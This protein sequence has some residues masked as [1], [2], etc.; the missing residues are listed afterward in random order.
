MA[1]TEKKQQLSKGETA[2]KPTKEPPP[3]RDTSI[4]GEKPYLPMRE[5]SWKLRR[6][7]PSIPG[8]PGLH[9]EKE[10][11][12]IAQDVERRFG[13]YLKRT[14]LPKLFRDLEIEKSKAPSI[15]EQ[16]NIEKKIRFLKR[17]LMGS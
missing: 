6:A 1:L 7:S 5:I 8:F 9:S 15:A 17:E 14:N 2:P 11:M 10:R 4:F 13:T 12:E 3:K 16:M